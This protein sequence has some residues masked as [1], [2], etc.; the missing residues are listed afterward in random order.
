MEPEELAMNLAGHS[1]IYHG[2][3]Y[4]SLDEKGVPE[5]EYWYTITRTSFREEKHW[6]YVDNRW[7][8]VLKE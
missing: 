8:E 3:A 5:L 2:N 6:R 4:L 1:E 7:V